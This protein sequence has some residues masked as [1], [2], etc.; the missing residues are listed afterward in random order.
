MR[1]LRI[2]F[3]S[4]H[5]LG[6]FFYTKIPSFGKWGLSFY[7]TDLFI[8]LIE[9]IHL[10]PGILKMKSLTIRL[11]KIFKCDFLLYISYW[12]VF[13]QSKT[14]CILCHSNTFHIVRGTFL[15]EDKN[16]DNRRILLWAASFLEWKDWMSELLQPWID[17]GAIQKYVELYQR[18]TSYA[19][20]ISLR[21]VQFLYRNECKIFYNKKYLRL[22]FVVR[23]VILVLRT[24]I[25]PLPAEIVAS[26]EAQSSKVVAYLRRKIKLNNRVA[27]RDRDCKL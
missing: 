13:T 15:V 11:W 7:W 4:V 5:F 2:P 14:V 17:V 9:V 26:S 20:S 12:K 3:F 21:V 25:M 22:P 19:S 1:N 18:Y 27:A 8:F 24:S 16:N 6:K 23:S 10:N